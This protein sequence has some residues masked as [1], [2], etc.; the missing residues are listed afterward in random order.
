MHIARETS[1]RVVKDTQG[2]FKLFIIADFDRNSA[3]DKVAV[4][5]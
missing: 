2:T 3:M 1:Y 4:K 5:Q